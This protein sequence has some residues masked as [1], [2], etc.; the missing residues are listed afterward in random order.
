[1]DEWLVSHA[2]ASSCG[3]SGGGVGS[4]GGNVAVTP[5]GNER[6]STVGTSGCCGSGGGGASGPSGTTTPVRKISAHEF[7]R[8]GLKPMVITV[9]GTPTFLASDHQ[10]ETTTAPV[11]RRRSRHE[12]RQLDE[13]QLIF[14]LVRPSSSSSFS[15][16][17]IL[18]L[19]MYTPAYN[20]HNLCSF[21]LCLDGYAFLQIRV[22]DVRDKF[23]Q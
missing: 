13:K 3:G 21:I 20:V 11:A 18:Y 1:M 16:H 14:E 15:S 5:T 4:S 19:V 17:S 22:L 7:E 8:G 6:Q 12:L 9:D 2:S 10:D 23:F